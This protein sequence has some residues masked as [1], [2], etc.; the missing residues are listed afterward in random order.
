MD[1][2]IDPSINLGGGKAYPAPLEAILRAEEAIGAHFQAGR[3]LESARV[4]G[5]V[6]TRALA[7]R[8]GVGGGA[9]C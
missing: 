6:H 7:S 9:K 1:L 8:H 5:A 4:I 2:N 3:T